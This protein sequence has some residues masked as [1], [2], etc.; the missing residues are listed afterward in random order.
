MKPL[1]NWNTISP[2][3][4]RRKKGGFM[5]TAAILATAL[6]ACGQAP[7]QEQQI[8]ARGMTSPKDI[9]LHGIIAGSSFQSNQ[10]FTLQNGSSIH[11]NTGLVLNSRNIVLNG[12][13]VSSTSAATCSDNSGQ[14]FCL[15]GK[16]KFISPIIT[17]PKPDVIALKAKYTAVPVVTIQGSLNLNSSSEITSRFDNKIVLVKGS[18]NLNAIATIKNAVLIIEE[19]L[20]S[21]KGMTLE[22]TRIIS[23]GAQFSQTTV[24]NNS[25]IITDEDLTFNGKLENTG[26]SSVVSS[27]NVST[28]QGATSASGELAVIANL[29]ITT[30][31]GSSGK[32]ALWA[33]GNITI[34]QSSSLEGSVVAGGKV[35]LNQ[36]VTLTKV[37]QHLNGDIL[38][39]GGFVLTRGPRYTGVV[40]KTQPFTTPDGLV[41]RAKNP[42][43]FGDI[44]AQVFGQRILP[45]D[46]KYPTLGGN[47]FQS[48]GWTDLVALYSLGT[49]TDSSDDYTYE[50]PIPDGLTFDEIG[51]LGVSNAKGVLPQVIP[52][53]TPREQSFAWDRIR[54]IKLN[55]QGKIQFSQSYHY[56]EGAF[57]IYRRRTPR[58][59][60]VPQNNPVLRLQQQQAD[61]QVLCNI[62]N[63]CNAT[64]V[65]RINSALNDAYTNLETEMG[66]A[67][68]YEQA[69]FSV[70]QED[71]RSLYCFET[72]WNATLNRYVYTTDP[73]TPNGTW[74]YYLA[75]QQEIHY[76][77]QAD[78]TLRFEIDSV[79]GIN[80]LTRH[81]M[82]HA[83]QETLLRTVWVT[84]PNPNARPPILGVRA[85][86]D[87]RVANTTWI[88]E[89]T[90]AAAETSTTTQMRK[91]D[92]YVGIRKI[93][94]T[95]TSV[96]DKN[97]YQAQDFLCTWVD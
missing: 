77:G 27:K 36:G 87:N 52:Q 5:L 81:E 68:R 76:C 38:G 39:G 70:D 21:N 49:A 17:V 72:E 37:L 33:G 7:V 22:N 47:I 20:K 45:E 18:V 50:L 42:S 97:Q 59:N 4:S 46:L 16:P 23:K 80:Q 48:E 74:A 89:A 28:N 2:K 8:Y 35:M 53:N 62:A 12:G 85:G 31:Q 88:V 63:A 43:E 10:G 25:R 41:M 95:L 26:I 3:N 30:N 13:Q 91:S 40:T 61:F 65:T 79:D 93:Q 29:N 60:V 71:G 19:T 6:Y 69:L 66:V 51:V 86:L 57:A 94:P 55:A 14:G 54:S 56:P 11:A 64:S 75:P 67:P 84:P 90:A 1:F 73:P 32:I 24:L 78:G 83:I 44:P 82:F 92:Y 9:M 15:N 34:N 96:T 58:Q